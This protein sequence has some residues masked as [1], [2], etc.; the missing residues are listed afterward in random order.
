MN[1]TD[2]TVWKKVG[3]FYTPYDVDKAMKAEGTEQVAKD[4]WNACLKAHG[5]EEGNKVK[6]LLEDEVNNFLMSKKIEEKEK[7]DLEEIQKKYIEESRR[8]FVEDLKKIEEISCAVLKVGVRY[9]DY[10]NGYLYRKYPNENTEMFIRVDNDGLSYLMYKK[11]FHNEKELACVESY[12]S[13][14]EVADNESEYIIKDF[15]LNEYN[16]ED[17]DKVVESVK[18]SIV[19]KTKEVEEATAD[20]INKYDYFYD[21]VPIT[22]CQS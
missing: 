16:T 6:G 8:M 12:V 4:S 3:D 20:A 19:G 14:G 10:N 7:T 21:R 17:I 2:K 5:L 18:E 13:S 11:S 9:G 22:D 1:E 15:L